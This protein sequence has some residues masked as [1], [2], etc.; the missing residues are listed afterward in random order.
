MEPADDQHR[1]SDASPTRAGD[2][3]PGPLDPPSTAPA[4]PR[5]ST[6]STAPP[7]SAAPAEPDEVK[8]G[9]PSTDVDAPTLTFPPPIGPG[10]ERPAQR[11][12]R[13][14]G[15]ER[16]RMPLAA[17]ALNRFEVREALGSGGMGKVVRAWDPVLCREVAI[18]VPFRPKSDARFLA[19]ARITG[20][21]DHPNIV[22][23]YELGK[24]AEGLPWYAMKEVRGE[25]LKAVLERL[26]LA[27]QHRAPWTLRALL[28]DFVQVCNAVGY[29]HDRGVVHRDLKPENIML[30]PFGEVFVMDWGLA[31]LLD[32]G[33]G[34]RDESGLHPS[35]SG[36]QTATGAAIG[37]PGFMSPEQAGRADVEVDARSDVWSLGAV[38]YE[39]L[40]LTPAYDGPTPLARIFAAAQGP[41]L[42]PRQRSPALRGADELADLCLRCLALEPH[43]RPDSA[44]VVA[45]EVTAY[46]EGTRRRERALDLL[47]RSWRSARDAAD[48]RE[49]AGRKRRDAEALLAGVPSHAPAE[50][51]LPGWRLEDE[52]EQLERAGDRADVRFL[53]LAHGALEEVPDLDEAHQL[54]ADHYRAQHTLAEQRRDAAAAGIHLLHL[55]EHDRG[56]HAR[57]LRGLGSVTLITDPPARVE[58]F[59]YE[60]RERRLQPC[61]RGELGVTPLIDV[62]LEHGSWLLVLHADG[63]A[64]VRYPVQVGRDGRWDGVRP[65]D[66]EPTPVRLPRLGELGPDDVYVPPGWAVSGEP[67]AD[68]AMPERRLWI[69]GFVLRRFAVTNAEYLDFL[70][71]LVRSGQEELAHRV[72][73]H[74]RGG[75]M[76]EGGAP[77]YGRT[78]DGG[79]E[80]V[81]DSEGDLW[82]PDWPAILV[83]WGSA[84][85]FARWES[86]RTGQPWRLP[87]ELEW[88]KA[89]RGVDAR[90]VPWGNFV[91]PAWACMS[92][93]AE[94]PILASVHAFPDDC[95]PYGVRGLGGN[96]KDWCG[97]AWREA[98]T[99][100]D[101]GLPAYEAPVERGLR[102]IR[103]GH[104]AAADT[105]LRSSLRV[106]SDGDACFERIGFRLARSLP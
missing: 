102:P 106:P 99:P 80:L 2:P 23:V 56:R 94:R 6:T 88:E 71:S 41:P 86:E 54:L 74:Q 36:V 44:L 89:A 55:Q 73:P 64:T 52:A 31:R 20:Q 16:P 83:D 90:R 51:K 13:R 8:P 32:R 12:A 34:E 62:E 42:D 97:D 92:G 47:E 82:Q 11:P 10:A 48:H 68:V 5:P 70:D 103:G 26:R 29:A 91:D 43:D 95:S 75:R 46:L 39:L 60:A 85:A 4:E 100:A 96:V 81:R 1:A 45:R 33:D 18:K 14:S 50:D 49:Q 25:S 57:Y 30:G 66:P 17:G 27:G 104:F 40:T 84:G 87:W 24:T 38:L 79:F 28:N 61:P 15:A 77:V 72:Q 59:R 58:L 35:F 78:A 105:L 21:L 76:D 67:D 37:T 98:G 101:G 9:D 69:D 53:Q 93:S 7:P 22:P 19:E 65:G 63:C 3:A